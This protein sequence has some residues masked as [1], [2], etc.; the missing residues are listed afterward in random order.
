MCSA[1]APGCN[2]AGDFDCEGGFCVDCA[3]SDFA[4]GCNCN[5][6]TDC[7]VGGYCVDCSCQVQLYKIN[8]PNITNKD[9]DR[10]IILT[11]K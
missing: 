8:K 4:A 6:D 7:P 3:C 5:A 11:A 9:P 2:C 10:L 1:F